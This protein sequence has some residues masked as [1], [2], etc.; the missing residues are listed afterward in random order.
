MNYSEIPTMCNG[1][2]MVD[3]GSVGQTIIVDDGKGNTAG[4]TAHLFQCPDCKDVAL[5]LP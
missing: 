5:L 2:E 3:I 1:K 4:G